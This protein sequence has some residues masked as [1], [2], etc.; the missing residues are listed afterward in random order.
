[1]TLSNKGTQICHF[2][3]ISNFANGAYSS[4]TDGRSAS[5]PCGISATQLRLTSCV[6]VHFLLISDTL[7]NEAF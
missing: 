3:D 7:D 6:P 5:C 2:I 1:M 4:H